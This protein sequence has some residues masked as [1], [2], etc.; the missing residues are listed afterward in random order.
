LTPSA[1]AIRSV[2]GKAASI[3]LAQPLYSNNKSEGAKLIFNRYGNRYFLSKVWT[4]GGAGR[5]L[6]RSTAEREL[7]AKAKSTNTVDLVAS[8]RE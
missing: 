3:T 8:S 6:L 5:E 2:N 1:L 4:S 7:I